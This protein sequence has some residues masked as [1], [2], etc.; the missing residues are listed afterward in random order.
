MEQRKGSIAESVFFFYSWG[1]GFVTYIAVM[2]IQFLD[3]LRG[4]AIVLVIFYHTFT[5]WSEYTPYGNRF[6]DFFLFQYGYLGVMLFFMISGFVI[7]MSLEKTDR[8]M[9]FLYKR[10]LRLFPAMVI[11]TILI[12]GTAH[13]LPERPWGIP[14]PVFTIPGLFF[15]D[16]SWVKVTT[17]IDVYPLEGSFWSLFVEW[18]FYLLFGFFYFTLGRIN[19]ILMITGFFLLSII[20][21]VLHN[22]D[23]VLLSQLLSFYYF[24]WFAIGALMYLYFTS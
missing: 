21:D 1:H 2:R 14:I 5:R 3:G 7:L 13:F 9:R 22:A 8:F 24:G 15:L 17:G 23:I 10:W 19:A 6:A 18:K 20:G 16:P 11:A 12:Y 4:V